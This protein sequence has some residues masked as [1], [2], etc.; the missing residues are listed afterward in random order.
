MFA[1]MS[2]VAIVVPTRGRP[3]ALDRAL[4]S[5]APQAKS[6]RAEL[7]VVEDGGGAAH[8][9]AARLDHVRFGEAGGTGALVRA[10]YGR[11]KVARRWSQSRGRAPSLQ[12]ELRV[13]AGSAWHLVRRRCMN[14]LLFA[15][16]AAGRVREAVSR[17]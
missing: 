17:G 11:G 7:I 3:P 12:G 6:V 10:A 8:A 5:I 16:D 13:L 14:G 15:A 1:P 2:A 4:A 9:V